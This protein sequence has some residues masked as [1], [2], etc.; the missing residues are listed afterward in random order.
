MGAILILI[1]FNAPATDMQIHEAEAL[2]GFQFSN[3]YKMFLRRFNGGF[4]CSPQ[5]KRATDDEALE[6]AKKSVHLENKTLPE[7]RRFLDRLQSSCVFYGLD[8][9]SEASIVNLE[10][11]AFSWGLP[12]LSV[13]TGGNSELIYSGFAIGSIYE[14]LIYDGFHE[15]PRSYWA[16]GFRSFAE[17]FVRGV[18]ELSI[19]GFDSLPEELEA[20]SFCFGEIMPP[21]YK[22]DMLSEVAIIGQPKN[23][24]TEKRTVE[25][26]GDEVILCASDI[27][28]Q[29]FLKTKESNRFRTVNIVSESVSAET[30]N[31]L[32][33]STNFE[34]ITINAK[35]VDVKVEHQ[36]CE[37]SKCK[38]MGVFAEAAADIT[39]WL[40]LAQAL[41]LVD[42]HS[43][44]GKLVTHKFLSKPGEVREFLPNRPNANESAQR[45]RLSFWDHLTVRD[46][47]G[48]I[49]YSDYVKANSIEGS[50]W[51]L[52]GIAPEDFRQ[53]FERNLSAQLI[54]PVRQ[55][56]SFFYL[57]PQP[58]FE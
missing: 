38:A 45:M 53:L 7:V 8:D 22:N 41:K 23:R 3:T 4:I 44:N 50:N 34:A 36:V 5:Q 30:L 1:F 29:N 15:V 54:V 46:E 25:K 2:Y 21:L 42:F 12:L 10:E 17:L 43:L 55:P 48:K 19:N 35:S 14:P 40:S 9:L 20:S 52:P 26:I 39:A 32:L 49:V 27:E 58:K 6:V 57:A 37:I 11:R 31:L 56:D 16:A 51:C 13:G 28:I 47:S 24:S 33:S 18:Q